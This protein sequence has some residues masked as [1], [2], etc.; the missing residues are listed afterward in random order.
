LKICEGPLHGG[1]LCLTD[2]SPGRPKSEDSHVAYQIGGTHNVAVK[3]G[4]AETRHCFALLERYQASRRGA[5]DAASLY[6]ATG[7]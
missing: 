5:L 2:C 1:H 6:T 3:T 7:A 4:E